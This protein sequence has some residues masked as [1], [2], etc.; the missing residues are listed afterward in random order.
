MMLRLLKIVNNR[1]TISRDEQ[2]NGDFFGLTLVLSEQGI[3]QSERQQGFVI[4]R[5]PP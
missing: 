4:S 3:L 5:L 2:T 1:V